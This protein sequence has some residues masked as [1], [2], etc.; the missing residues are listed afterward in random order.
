KPCVVPKVKGKT[1]K[2]AKR[3]I[4]AHACTVGTVK[5]ATSRTVKKGHVISQ[6]PKPG[7]RL[8]HGAKVNLVVSKGRP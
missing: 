6:K 3:A 5:R 7:R 1:L 8:R 2:K 4:R